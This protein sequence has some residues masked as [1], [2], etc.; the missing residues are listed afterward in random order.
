M[1]SSMDFTAPIHCVLFDGEAFTFYRFDGY[2]KPTF[3]RGEFPGYPSFT[4]PDSATE[5]VEFTKNLRPVCE[6]IFN[7]LLFS[8]RSGLEAQAKRST[9]YAEQW[10]AATSS[11]SNAIDMCLVAA[12]KAEGSNYA[13]ANTMATVGIQNLQTRFIFSFVEL[14][15]DA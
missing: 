1:N 14:M 5:P 13:E 6:I 11:T 8:Y 2:N 15:D 7:I 3:A 12:E 4:V 9:E 10:A